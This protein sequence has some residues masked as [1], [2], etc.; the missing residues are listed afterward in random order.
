MGGPTR[1]GNYNLVSGCL[2]IA[3]LWYEEEIRFDPDR[4]WEKTKLKFLKRLKPD[5]RRIAH[6]CESRRQKPKE[7][8]RAFAAGPQRLR[9]QVRQHEVT[10]TGQF[11]RNI[12]ASLRQRVQDHMPETMEAA[13]K[14]AAYSEATDEEEKQRHNEAAY[15]RNE[16]FSDRA[17]QNPRGTIKT[18]TRSKTNRVE[19]KD[20]LEMNTMAHLSRTTGHRCRAT[21]ILRRRRHHTRHRGSMQCRSRRHPC[22]KTISLATSNL[23]SGRTQ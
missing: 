22:S 8:V 16:T 6:L 15:S 21:P 20:G 7:D 10:S 11:I 5:I 3:H 17:L 9:A 23:G 13:I 12:S 14:G 19:D 2:H 1:H 18:E 4:K